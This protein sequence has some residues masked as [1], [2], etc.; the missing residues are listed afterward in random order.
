MRTEMTFKIKDGPKQFFLNLSRSE[1]RAG[2][3]LA[4]CLDADR[5]E[6][7][8]HERPEPGFFK[9]FCVANFGTRT[10]SLTREECRE[11]NSS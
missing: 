1:F 2:N 9:I 8:F 11:G 10:D 7:Y 5:N 6:L 4:S 3:M